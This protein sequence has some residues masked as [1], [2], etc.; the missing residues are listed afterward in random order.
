MARMNNRAQT[1]MKI[2]GLALAVTV[3]IIVLSP[4]VASINDSTGV[5]TVDNETFTA[6]FGNYTEISGYEVDGATVEVY[7]DGTQVSSNNFTVKEQEGQIKVFSNASNDGVSDGESV[8]TT[9]DYQATGGTVTTVVGFVP[10]MLGVLVMV[11]V[12]RRISEKM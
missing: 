10:V 5:Q 9:Y 11:A 3:G 8:T 6:D 1:G 4:V 2:L 7:D 12:S